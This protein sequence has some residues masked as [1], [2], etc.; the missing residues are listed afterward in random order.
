MYTKS[1]GKSVAASSLVWFLPFPVW[2]KVALEG[3]FSPKRCVKS[4]IWAAD[5]ARCFG[6]TPMVRCSKTRPM[7]L[8]SVKWL[9][10]VDFYRLLLLLQGQLGTTHGTQGYD[11][12]TTK[13][14]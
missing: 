7:H 10:I 11:G 6:G 12:E 14:E 8:L 1:S 5:R 2:L 3:R 13:G 4:P 9:C